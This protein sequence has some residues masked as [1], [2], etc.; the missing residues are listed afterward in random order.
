MVLA[1]YKVI[2]LVLDAKYG[3]KR[4]DLRIL[5]RDRVIRLVITPGMKGQVWCSI[6]LNLDC[7]ALL[8]WTIKTK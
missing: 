1:H 3:D 6:S 8:C 5:G 4:Q 7:V 2:F